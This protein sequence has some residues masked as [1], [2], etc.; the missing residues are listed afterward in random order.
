MPAKKRALK[1]KSSDRRANRN[2]RGGVGEAIFAEAEKLMAAEKI[3][4]TEAFR[5][6]AQRSGRAEG[7]VAANYYRIANKR[8]RPLRSRAG[9]GGTAAGAA[10]VERV[11]R[12]LETI[13]KSQQAEIDQLRQENSQFAAV[14]RLLHKS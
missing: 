6:I 12:D 3:G 2:N 9:S 13:L 4:P 14:K 8:G 11:L 5:I 1:K 7:T 10:R